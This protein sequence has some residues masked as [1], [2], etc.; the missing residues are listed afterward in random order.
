MRRREFVTLLGD[1]AMALLVLATPIGGVPPAMA[2]GYPSRP[3]TMIV[4]YGAGGPTDT[5]GRI[6]AEGMRAFL[7][8]PVVIENVTGASGVI[9]VGRA[10][11]APGDGYTLSLGGWPSHVLN[12]AIF[13]VDYDVLKDFEPVSPL[14]SEPLLIV[15]KQ[16]M[17][18]RDLKELVAWLK[19]NPG[20][21]SLGTTGSGGALHV[22]GVLFQRDTGTHLQAIPY[23]GGAAPAL[24]DLVAGQIDI[25]IDLTA[26]SLPQIRS[27]KIKAY[28]VTAKNRLAAAPDIP[29]TDEAGLA[30]FHILNWHGLWVPKDTPKNVTAKIAA[31][32]VSSLHNPAARRRLADLGQEIFPRSQQTPEELALLQ[33]A[34]IE[35]WWPLIKSAGIKAD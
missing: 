5:I 20:K 17:P 26:S 4:P 19:A 22:A 11:R 13:T 29:T 33:N 7:G 28:A 34:E 27:G 8:Q 15:A 12:S 32:V 30:G 23:R 18:A 3:I 21:A 25:M 1:A 16:A 31:A 6:V 14:V 9:G 2:E 24:Q 35:K 10:A